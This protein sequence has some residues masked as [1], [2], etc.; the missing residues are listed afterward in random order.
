VNPSDLGFPEQF[1]EFRPAQIEATEFT[2]TTEK[3]FTGLGLPPGCGKSPLALKLAKLFGGRT[4]ILTATLGLQDQYHQFKSMGL[5]DIRGRSHF[6][7]WEG[8]SCEDGGRM[9]C[10]DKGGCPYLGAYRAQEASDIVVTSYAYWLA[11]SEKGQG[12]RARGLSSRS[13]SRTGMRPDQPG[14]R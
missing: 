9:G 8:G 10:K 3:R 6:S 12:M 5:I 1:T 4:V 14:F 2:L 11:I 13:G 7:C